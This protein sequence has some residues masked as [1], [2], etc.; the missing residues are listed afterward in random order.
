MRLWAIRRKS[1]GAYLPIRVGKRGQTA[2]EPSLKE[3]PRLFTRKS[4]ATSAM[5][6]W[7]QG[8]W[9]MERT[10]GP[11]DIW[12]TTEYEETLRLR[13]DEAERKEHARMEAGYGWDPYVEPP[14]RNADDFEV[15][16]VEIRI[17]RRRT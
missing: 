6:W 1:D 11:S 7:A 9:W 8:I 15:V 17:D 13:G 2:S 14:K 5:R 4:S 3:P 16:R 12:G 10:S